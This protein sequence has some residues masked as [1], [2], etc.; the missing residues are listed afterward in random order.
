MASCCPVPPCYF[1]EAFCLEADAAAGHGMVGQG[2]GGVH[3]PACHAATA[4]HWHLYPDLCT[5][6]RVA[7][8]PTG[9]SHSR[10]TASAA[11]CG[12]LPAGNEHLCRCIPLPGPKCISFVLKLICPR[13]PCW[14]RRMQLPCTHGCKDVCQASS[15]HKNRLH[16]CTTWTQHAVLQRR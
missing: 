15:Q 13:V 3:S 16:S 10:C 4:A 6:A 11:A 12:A 7:I 9:P 5:A 1:A 2:P 8:H 14:P